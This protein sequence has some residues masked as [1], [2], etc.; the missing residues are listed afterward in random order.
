LVDG[1]A[2]AGPEIGRHEKTA[3]PIVDNLLL[4]F[5]N[6]GAAFRLP[7]AVRRFAAFLP[8]CHLCCPSARLLLGLRGGT[9]CRCSLLSRS[10]M[11][12]PLGFRLSVQILVCIVQFSQLES[13][14]LR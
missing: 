11:S 8:R 10:P 13:D 5:L 4:Y 3:V 14:A 12:V 7:F 6:G 2:D 1:D 9:F